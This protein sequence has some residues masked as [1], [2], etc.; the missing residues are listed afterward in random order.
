MRSN[1]VEP[2][3]LKPLLSGAF[4][5][6]TE[7]LDPF[8]EYVP[9]DKMAAF[10]AWEASKE[11]KDVV[12]T[13]LVLARRFGFPVVVAAVDGSPAA[14]AG[15][16]SDD[17]IE[18][19]DGSPHAQHGALGARS[20]ALRKGRR[21]GAPRGRARGQAPPPDDRHRARELVAGD[22]VGPARRRRDGHPHPVL[23]TGLRRGGPEDPRAARPHP[24]AHPRRAQQR[25]RHLRGGGARRRAVRVGGA[26]GR[27]QG[28]EDRIEDATAPSRASASTRAVSSSS[29]TAARPG[30][31]SSSPR[32]CARRRS[33]RPP[34]RSSSGTRRRRRK[35]RTPSTST[36]ASNRRRASRSSRC[37]SSGRRPSAWGSRRRS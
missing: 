19:V 20:A 24:C 12:D 25:D 31:R 36:R 10:A 7:A 27:A 3:E 29:S 13:G 4:S 5:G 18:K 15:V 32:R 8:S 23:R 22:P 11:K 28:P 16:K 30:P 34:R 37:G 2:V 14:A 6:M 21:P 26:A 1:Y 33:A 35:T 17:V 9:P